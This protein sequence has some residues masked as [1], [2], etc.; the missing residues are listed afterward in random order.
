MRLDSSF[1]RINS[2]SVNR[3]IIAHEINCIIFRHIIP[4]KMIKMYTTGKNLDNSLNF[5]K[6][7]L[8][9]NAKYKKLLPFLFCEI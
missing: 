3:L 1:G 6:K 7:R 2:E 9:Y 5:G 4:Y 8:I